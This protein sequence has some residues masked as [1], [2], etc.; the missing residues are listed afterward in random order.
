MEISA[1]AGP[2]IPVAIATIETKNLV[3]ISNLCLLFPRFE[4]QQVGIED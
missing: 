4:N 3:F 1:Q 2:A